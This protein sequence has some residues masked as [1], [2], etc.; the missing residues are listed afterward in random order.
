MTR[1]TLNFVF[2]DLVSSLEF[3]RSYLDSIFLKKFC[4]FTKCFIYVWVSIIYAVLEKYKNVI[5]MRN[6]QNVLEI[7][8]KHIKLT[9]DPNIYLFSD[10]F[11]QKHNNRCHWT[12]SFGENMTITIKYSLFWWAVHNLEQRYLIFPTGKWVHLKNR[13][14]ISIQKSVDMKKYID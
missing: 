2:T 5:R 4:S 10:S 1:S 12:C 13:N 8:E 9:M 6:D 7:H 11:I 3:P 14:T